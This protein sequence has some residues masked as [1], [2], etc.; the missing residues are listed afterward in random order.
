MKKMSNYRIGLAIG[1]KAVGYAVVDKTGKLA[2]FKG[3]NMWGISWMEAA[4]R[5]ADDAGISPADSIGALQELLSDRLSD[6]DAGFLSRVRRRD[7]QENEFDGIGALMGEG[8]DEKT[9]LKTCPTVYH[10]RKRLST[11]QER[12][13]LRLIYLA[14]HHIVKHGGCPDDGLMLY[15]KH[16]A[17][18]AALKRLY[19]KY[20]PERYSAMFRA[21][22]PRSYACYMGRPPSCTR[23]ELYRTIGDVLDKHAEDTEASYCISEMR[24]GTFLPRMGDLAPYRPCGTEE[25]VCMLAHQALYDPFLS[26]CQ[27]RVVRLI[28]KRGADWLSAYRRAGASHAARIVKEIIKLRQNPPEEVFFTYEEDGTVMMGHDAVSHRL[29]SACGCT[30]GFFPSSVLTDIKKDCGLYDSRGVS[31]GF[32]AQD[33]FLAAAAGMNLCTAASGEIRPSVCREKADR[34]GKP[35]YIRQAFGFCSFFVS[36]FCGG[37]EV[38]D[39]LCTGYGRDV[40]VCS[41]ADARRRRAVLGCRILYDGKEYGV[42]AS[43]ELYPAAVLILSQKSMRILAKLEED[44]S[45]RD[46]CEEEAWALYE[47]LSDKAR[48]LG[49]S[50]GEKDPAAIRREDFLLLEADARARILFDLL[51]WVRAD[52]PVISAG[53]LDPD[54]VEILDRSVTGLFEKKRKLSEL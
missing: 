32:Y 22:G 10:L 28:E 7:I 38:T 40:A 36:G 15:E 45:G 29:A 20:A 52:I 21:A 2:R 16:K 31:S 5:K 33:A 14:L 25:A 19:R 48:R 51:G 24:K 27:G 39:R 26:E 4:E 11:C 34:V 6:L 42:S 8:F 13:D 18:L 37:G 43:G 1:R 47:E 23:A 53:E 3:K 9:Y 30:P 50:R 41:E 44:K 12:M 17:D 49:R 35:C 46:I 54:R